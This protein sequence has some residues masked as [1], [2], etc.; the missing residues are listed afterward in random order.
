M[1]NKPNQNLD[2]NQEMEKGS[3]A[4]IKEAERL[5]GIGKHDCEFICAKCGLTHPV[6]LNRRILLKWCEEQIQSA[7][8]QG[9]ED[10]FKRPKYIRKGQQIFNFLEWVQK[11]KGITN[12]QSNRMADP[13]YFSDTQWDSYYQEFCNSLS[14]SEGSIDK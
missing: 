8:L 9:Y 6:E 1:A 2:T 7:R 12:E 14:N 4:A 3:N 10:A 11:E 5:K 13:F